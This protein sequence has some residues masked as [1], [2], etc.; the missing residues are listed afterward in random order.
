[1]VPEKLTAALETEIIKEYGAWDIIGRVGTA[2]SHSFGAA[3]AF[4]DVSGAIAKR[5][6]AG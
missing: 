4:F 6:K 5:K 2:L 1:V 3:A